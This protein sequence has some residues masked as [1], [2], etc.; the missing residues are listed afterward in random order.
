[1]ACLT[2]A[3][4]WIE[5]TRERPLWEAVL[6][7]SPLICLGTLARESMALLAIV[8]VA[9]RARGLRGAPDAALA[10]VPLG[11]SL[12]AILMTRHIG[13]A[14]NDY[15]PWGHLTA[16]VT[17]KPVYTWV[18]AWF[19]AFGP[20][21][22]ALIVSARR[23]VWRWLRAR[24]ALLVHLGG[25]GVLAYLGG[26]DTER[27]L[28]WAAPVVLV[29]GGIAIEQRWSALRHAPLLVAVL[30][31]VHVASS[32]ILWPIPGA[33]AGVVPIAQLGLNWP[34]A[35]QVLDRL[36]VIDNHY[37]N[38]WSYFGSRGLKAAILA[39]DVAFVLAVAR[40]IATRPTMVR[41][42]GRFG[43]LLGAR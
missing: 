27:I 17:T 28:G 41:R 13:V 14:T 38:L 24:P 35:Y 39:F 36:L 15:E 8:F 22:I 5:R 26:T 9:D 31:V 40:L 11:A 2:A 19:F 42:P 29:L 25:C 21:M 12:A 20:P 6:L 34:S 7:L 33:D 3:L 23:E 43:H 16:M 10:V 32:R 18:L 37:V 4:W 1:M 30:V